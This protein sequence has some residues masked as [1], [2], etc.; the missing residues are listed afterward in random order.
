[1]YYTLTYDRDES[2]LKHLS[3]QLP[4][5]ISIAF[6]YTTFTDSLTC[7]KQPQWVPKH[8]AMG[9]GKALKLAV[10]RQDQLQ[11]MEARVPRTRRA[12]G[13]ETQ[14][15]VA[16]DASLLSTGRGKQPPRRC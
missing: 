14:A 11:G 10:Q 1:M 16:R 12:V 2:S 4:S 7:P 8:R 9:L 5:C 13:S 3:P 6:I 15:P